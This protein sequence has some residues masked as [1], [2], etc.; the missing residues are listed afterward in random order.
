MAA[1]VAVLLLA[2]PA[3]AATITVTSNADSG[4]GSLRE[5]IGVAAPG[6]TIDFLAQNI[7]VTSGGL[8]INKNLTIQG[9]VTITAR[10]DPEQAPFF[11]LTVT[12]GQVL[13][14]DVHVTGSKGGGISNM[15]TLTVRNSTISNNSGPGGTGIASGGALTVIDST[16]SDNVAEIQGGGLAI[17]GPGAT[18]LN[19]TISGNSAP[20]GGGIATDAPVKLSNCTISGNWAEEGGA[21]AGDTTNI[22]LLNCTVCLNTATS[23]GPGIFGDGVGVLMRNTILQGGIAGVSNEITAGSKNNLTSIFLIEQLIGPLA[24]NGGRTLTHA[25]LPNSSAINAGDNEAAST[26]VTDQ[27]GAGFVRRWGG[28]VDIGAFEL[29]PTP[30]SQSLTS[31]DLD[32]ARDAIL[33]RLTTA[34]DN[35]ATQQSVIEV[36]NALVPLNGNLDAKVSSR[37]TP[38]DITDARDSIV[39]G[40]T[41]ATGPLARQETLVE[42]RNLLDSANGKLDANVSSRA[43]HNDI[44][45]LTSG[46]TALASQASVTQLNGNVDTQ[47]S[48]RASQ[49]SVTALDT[50]LDQHI[51]TY[52]GDIDVLLRA[53][54]EHAFA[55][56]TRRITLFYLPAANGGQAEFVKQVVRDAYNASVAAGQLTGANQQSALSQLNAGDTAFAQGKFKT[57]YDN[58]VTAYR[59]IVK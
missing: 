44:L 38:Q 37:A 19:S 30:V 54:I 23:H 50:K 43:S 34:P 26:L 12:G 8:V 40:I 48:S 59:S 56:G 9:P 11:V 39:G 58:Y 36:K 29:Q 45:A 41:S 57:A 10:T 25:L 32:A 27:R 4:N 17:S 7:T 28:N 3:Q 16:I 49:A 13:I 20:W 52:N 31:L 24:N 14:S 15:G 22:E 55:E 33:A 42:A 21:I 6:D 5:A 35:P 2:G 53:Q 46:P 1:S 18:I 51:N 47:V